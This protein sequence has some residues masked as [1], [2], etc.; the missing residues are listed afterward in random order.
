M[1]E[2]FV[3]L[4]AD[5]AG[6]KLRTYNKDGAGAS[7]GSHDQ[8]VIP[9]TERKVTGIYRAASFR[10]PG[11]ASSPTNLVTIQN[12]TG[13]SSLVA[14]RRVAVDVAVSAATADLVQ[15]YIRLFIY[16]G[17][18]PT[19]GTLATKHKLDSTYAASQSNTEIRFPASA[20]GTASAITHA[21]PSGNPA[22]QQAHPLAMTAVGQ[23]VT[24]DLEIQ[25]YDRPPLIL[26]AGE[27]L[28]VAM[29]GNSATDRH[30]VVKVIWEEFTY[31]A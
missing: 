18:T 8:Y 5:G 14:V 21:L 4:P 11:A 22:A 28:L 27:T 20:D 30:Y 26:R 7:P 3:Q 25:P 31:T 9:T 16:T 23:W 19:G 13:A 24:D 15:K 6:K 1:A 10:L 12:T 2:S 17:V 29:I